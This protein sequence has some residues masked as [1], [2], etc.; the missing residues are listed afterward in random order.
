[1]RRPCLNQQETCQQFGPNLQSRDVDCKGAE[2]EEILDMEL[3]D[4]Q[5]KSS[6]DLLGTNDADSNDC[7]DESEPEV[8]PGQAV[9][10]QWDPGGCAL[11]KN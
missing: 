4:F 8:Q 9:T 7:D 6:T 11:N 10:R 2:I 5:A 3:A 1:M